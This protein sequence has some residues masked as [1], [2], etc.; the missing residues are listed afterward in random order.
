MSMIIDP[1]FA[2]NSIRDPT[3]RIVEMPPV[4]GKKQKRLVEYK[5]VDPTLKA[6]GSV[7]RIWPCSPVGLFDRTPLRI[8][9]IHDVT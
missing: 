6:V 9:K 7:V 2:L 8:E 1:R 3:V 5:S 4:F